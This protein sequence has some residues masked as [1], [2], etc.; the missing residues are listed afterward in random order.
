MLARL[1]YGKVKIFLSSPLD[2]ALRGPIL[3]GIRGYGPGKKEQG[4]Q[5]KL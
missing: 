3:F 4:E 5:L 1:F 2:A